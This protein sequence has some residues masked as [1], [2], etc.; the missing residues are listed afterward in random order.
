[1][2]IDVLNLL[3]N[4]IS[5]SNHTF[6]FLCNIWIEIVDGSTSQAGTSIRSASQ[7]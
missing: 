2:F 4:I 1:M 7:N 6:F 3:F 5:Y